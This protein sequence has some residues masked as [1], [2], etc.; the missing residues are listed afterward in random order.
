L[1]V[2]L[3]QSG[4]TDEAIEQYRAELAVHPEQRG[5]QEGLRRLEA[6]LLTR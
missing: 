5:A 4:R 3:E 6:T 2:A 1:A